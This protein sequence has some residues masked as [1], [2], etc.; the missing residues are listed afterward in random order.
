[1][2]QERAIRSASG[3]LNDA[4]LALVSLIG[5]AAFCLSLFPARLGTAAAVRRQRGPR[6]GRDR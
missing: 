2:S 6:A 4:I 1:M 5:V 3:V